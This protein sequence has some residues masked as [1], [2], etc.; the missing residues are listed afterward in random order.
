MN[1]KRKRKDFK[2]KRERQQ[3]IGH[4]CRTSL[5]CSELRSEAKPSPAN[6]ERHLLTGKRKADHGQTCVDVHG[7]ANRA[8]EEEEGGSQ[9]RLL[10]QKAPDVSEG[11]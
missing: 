9:A 4:F 6:P 5:I 7:A 1:Q 10:L 8:G 2:R 11:Q 3:I